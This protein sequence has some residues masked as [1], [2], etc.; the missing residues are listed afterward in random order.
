LQENIDG[1]DVNCV[2]D[3]FPIERVFRNI[4]ENSLA[5][6][7]DPLRIDARCSPATLDDKPAVRI[8][9]ADNGPG[10]NAEERQRIFEP[11]FTTKTKGT[12][13]GMAIVK[14]IVDAHGGRIS[15]CDDQVPGTTV[16]IILPKG[17]T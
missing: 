9:L 1:V 3:S 17:R 2:A 8:R 12:G 10:L 5:A 16:E 6:C 13:L 7:P 4:F 14:R 15:V 11:F